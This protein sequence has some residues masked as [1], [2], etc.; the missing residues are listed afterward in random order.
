MRFCEIYNTPYDGQV[1]VMVIIDPNDK[2]D[3]CHVTATMFTRGRSVMVVKPFDHVEDALHCFN[4]MNPLMI[5][6]L[7]N[8]VAGRTDLPIDWVEIV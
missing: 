2:G 7:A 6:V 5:D 3:S 4:D 1:C 8:A